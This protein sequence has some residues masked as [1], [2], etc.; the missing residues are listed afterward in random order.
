MKY[1]I[2]MKKLELIVDTKDYV[3]D[4]IFSDEKRLKRVIFNL[5]GNACKFTFK[6]FIKLS[7]S[8]EKIRSSQE[9]PSDGCFF[10]LAKR[11]EA[12]PE[13]RIN[14][15]VEDSGIGIKQEDLSKLFKLFGKLKVHNNINQNGVGLGLTIS[16]KIT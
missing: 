3:P 14:I 1:Q 11:P 12:Y 4:K 5:L 15:Q 6:G 8:A 13:W 2:K 7:I 16:Q 10:Q 9:A